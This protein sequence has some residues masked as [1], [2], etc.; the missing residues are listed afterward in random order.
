MPRS[1]RLKSRERK[2]EIHEGRDWDVDEPHLGD[3]RAETGAG[4]A[5]H[6]LHQQES[7]QVVARLRLAPHQLEG[8][9][10]HLRAVGVIS[11]T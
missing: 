2:R 11:A 5:R 1:S 3:V 4:A 9:V 7:P 8:G 6:G 10:A